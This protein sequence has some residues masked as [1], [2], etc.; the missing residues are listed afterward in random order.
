MVVDMIK[1]SEA[2]EQKKIFEWA[3]YIPELKW[4]HCIPNGGSRNIREAVN[5]KRQGVKKGIA[6][7]FLPIPKGKYHGLYIEL[8]VGKNKLSVYQK[9]F[10]EYANKV[11]YL[12]IVCY[13]HE[14]AIKCITEYLKIG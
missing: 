1:L 11:G 4:L 12:A 3:S 14:E 7:M 10:L 2:E 6:D 13:G 8:K 9:E 5:L